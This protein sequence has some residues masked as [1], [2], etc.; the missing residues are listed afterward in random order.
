MKRKSCRNGFTLIEILVTI[1]IIGVIGTIATQS[2]FSLLRGASKVEIVKELKQSGDYVI[3]TL[4]VDIR[5]AKDVA[6][7]DASCSIMVGVNGCETSVSHGACLRIT[8]INGSY[9]YYGCLAN[10]GINRL[11]RGGTDY[12]TNSSVAV[13][14]CANVFVCSNDSAGQVAK[15]INI[16]FTLQQSQA[17]ANAAESA[18]QT[19]DTQ[20]VLRNK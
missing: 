11:T 17:T 12:L 19:F 10:G 4:Q 1:V 2:L 5:N 9:G 7:F 13:T 3:S 8:N 18:T 20:I 14:D 6:V 16:N 15:V